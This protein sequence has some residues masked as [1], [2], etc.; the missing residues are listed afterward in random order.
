MKEDIIDLEE[1]RLLDAWDVEFSM[2][3]RNW[4]ALKAYNRYIAEKKLKKELV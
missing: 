3:I 2:W 1:D 4:P